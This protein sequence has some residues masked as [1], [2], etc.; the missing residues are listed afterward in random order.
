MTVLEIVLL[1]VF[2]ILA[3]LIFLALFVYLKIKIM[4]K[5]AG[6]DNIFKEIKDS[7]DRIRDSKKSISGMTRLLEPLISE[8]FKTFNKEELFNRSEKNLR[9]VFSALENYSMDG[10]KDMPLLYEIVKKEIEDMRDNQIKVEYNDIVF[11]DFAI[12]NYHKTA[13]EA[14]IEIAVS[15]QYSYK[16]YKKNKLVK[17][18]E[19]YQT[20]Y[21]VKFIY[22]IDDVLFT[23]SKK[24]Y[25]ITCPNCGAA[26]KT[27]GD[28][29]CA[30][31]GA[32]IKDINL[33]AWFMSSYQEY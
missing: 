3:F 1:V 2:S 25:G 4:L 12:K 28:K 29:N 11:H 33:K 23:K 22:I 20:R 18:K 19:N 10:F 21:L 17:S 9:T 16:K 13:S 24:V 26:I 32:V 5:K 15:L 8:D 7:S 14:V 6:I 30:Y 31:C 27:L